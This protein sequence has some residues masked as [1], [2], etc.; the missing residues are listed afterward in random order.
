MKGTVSEVI[1]ALM[2]KYNI[3]YVFGLPAAQISGFMDGVS[4]DADFKY[5]TTRHEEAAAHM[6][7][8]I[9]KLTNTPALCFGTVGPGATNLVP[10]VAAAWMDN[11]PMVVLTA[12]NQSYAAILDTD[13]LQACNQVAL[14]SPVTKWNAIITNPELAPTLIERA[15]RNTISDRPGPVHIDLPCDIGF[16]QGDYD[17]DLSAAQP[18]PTPA[19]DPGLIESAVE[20]LLSA[21]R[22]CILGGGGVVRSGALNEFRSLLGKTGFAAISTLNGKG[23]IPPDHPSHI[24]SAGFLGGHGVVKALQEAD[25]ILAVGCKFSSWIPIQK[26]PAY[27]RVEGQRII[28]VDID[29]E[30][31]GKNARI[32]LGILAD[33]RL[34][35]QAIIDALGDTPVFAGDTAWCDSLIRQRTQ[36]LNEVNDIA[37]TDIIESSGKLSSAAVIKALADIVGPETIV[38]V[39]GGQSMQWAHTY[40]QTYDPACL[41]YNPGMG[42]LGSG[43]PFANAAKFAFPERQVVNIVGDGACGCTIQELETA[44]RHKLNAVHVV[45]NDSHW[46]MYRPLG[47]VIFA[48]PD[49][50]T[51]LSDVDYAAIAR[52][53]G[54]HGERVTKLEELAP[55]FQRA[56]ESGRPAVLDVV[57]DFVAH[58]MDFIWP[59]VVLADAAL[60]PPRGSM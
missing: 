6:A 38:V 54:C 3:R 26:P 22:P 53:F 14:Y 18:R 32:D 33:A 28:Q 31:L 5:L 48:N 47:E 55:A 34:A 58:P 42:H 45:I 40:I 25:V 36:Y 41:L 51:S 37:E 19:P 30:I 46:G 60:P 49:F 23:L 52:G 35:L 59:E 50:G 43:T 21:K 8:A 12:N 2:K 29:S 15:M 44:A 1:I 57:A 11:V 17:V 24:G 10:G 7:H 13:L 39:D 20:M 9:A 56:L 27:P 16:M 4:T